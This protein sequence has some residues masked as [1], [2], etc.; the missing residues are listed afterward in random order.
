MKNLKDKS[1]TH[2]TLPGTKVR[3]P[4]RKGD[5]VNNWDEVCIWAMDH[6]GLPGYKF[7]THLTEECMDFYFM[8]ERDAV[9]FELRWG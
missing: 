3:I 1:Q 7:T 5:T 9:L 2:S 8:D 4:W 6:F